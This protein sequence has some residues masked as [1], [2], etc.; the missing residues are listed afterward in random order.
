[1]LNKINQRL[2]QLLDWT[3][4][5]IMGATVVILF[6]GVILR[7][8]FSAPLFW[9]EEVAVLGLI[10]ITFLGGAILVRQDK[11]VCI[12]FFSDN[13]P[14]PMARRMKIL[15]DIL[16]IIMLCV[17]I[18]QSWKLTGRLAF[19]TTPALRI[20]ESWFGWAMISGFI[21]MLYYQIQ[22]LISLLRNKEPF[23]E[24]EDRD[25]GCVL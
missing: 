9:S 4:G 20:K 6:V 25:K 21:I 16:V 17:M 19:S 13:C 3:I 2:A 1:M 15:S 7:Y 14:A 5:L 18:Y 22:R 24:M 8:V 11:N 10:W 12:T 23:P